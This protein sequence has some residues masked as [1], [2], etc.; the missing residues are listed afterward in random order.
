MLAA[1]LKHERGIEAK[2]TPGESGEFTVLLDGHSIFSKKLEGRF[3]ET[4]EILAQLPA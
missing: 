3:P 4:E 2:V 1:E